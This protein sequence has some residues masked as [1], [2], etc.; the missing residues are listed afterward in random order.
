MIR[1][2]IRQDLAWAG[3]ILILAAAFGLGQQWRLVRLSWTGGLTAHLE[4]Q[5]EQRR[6][7][8]FQGV[9]TLN[10]AQAYELFQQGQARFIDARNP[11]EYAELHIAGAVNLSPSDLKERGDRPLAGIPTERQLVVYCGQINCDAAL[12][13]AENLQAHG[14]SRVAAFLGGFQAWDQ[15][16]YPAD[17]SK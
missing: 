10:L 5:R 9:P 13:V 17:T 14:F 7:T 6:R 11:E 2:L 15:A 4:E 8:E 12:K 16:G 3:F 1:R